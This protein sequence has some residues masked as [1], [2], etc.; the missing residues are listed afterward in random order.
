MKRSALSFF[1]LTLLLVALSS[2]D[3]EEVAIVW[4]YDFS[5]C[6][7][8]TGSETLEVV[9]FNIEH[10]NNSG[11]HD[12]KM[13][14]RLPYIASL[15][16]QL[17]ADVVAI[18]EI[19][20]EYWTSRLTDELPGWEGVFTPKSSGDQSLAYIY[21]VSEID[22]ITEET[23]AILSTDWY[24]FPRAPMKIKVHHKGSGLQVYMINNH[25]K[26]CGGSDNEERRRDAS[27]KLKQYI[28]DNLDDQM[29][30]VL[31]DYNDEI[32]DVYTS[33]NVF[34]NFIEDAANYRFA[35]MELANSDSEYWSYPSWPSHIDHI[36]ISNELF[37]HHHNT[38]TIRP[39]NCQADFLKKG[40][41]HRPV[42]SIFKP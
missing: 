20:S 2:C 31:G 38:V 15:I 10:F 32:S 36:L 26:C 33:D 12:Y 41:D 8:S 4:K 11:N 29:V 21:K 14:E 16:G 28:D 1:L 40:S 42:M 25:L 23:E 37:T 24:A 13:S 22:L 7:V 9:T 35:D 17:D 30:V 5:D 18:Q 19:G 6:T 27:E 34:W 39:S 3:K